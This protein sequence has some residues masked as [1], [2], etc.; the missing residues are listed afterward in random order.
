MAALDYDFYDMALSSSSLTLRV[1]PLSAGFACVGSVPEH[2]DAGLSEKL[3][4]LLA[5]HDLSA[6]DA[7]I[8]AF[9]ESLG[10]FQDPDVRLSAQKAEGGRPRRSVAS[11][12][13]KPFDPAGYI[14][15]TQCL[16]AVRDRQAALMNMFGGQGDN[17]DAPAGCD[18]AAGGCTPEVVYGIATCVDVDGDRG[19]FLKVLAALEGDRDAED[20]VGEHSVGPVGPSPDGIMFA[21]SFLF[22]VVGAVSLIVGYF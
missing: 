16:D 7:K 20:G 13:K 2:P 5:H 8:D 15:E 14:K 3:R 4:E 9:F 10:A 1:L 6:G 19:F 18:E 21:V 12:E 22:D 11:E 17:N